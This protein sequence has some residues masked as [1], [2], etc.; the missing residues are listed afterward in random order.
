MG[1]LNVPTQE[2]GVLRLLCVQGQSGLHMA[3]QTSQSYTV[4]SG[5]QKRKGKNLQLGSQLTIRVPTDKIN[6]RQGSWKR[7]WHKG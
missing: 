6:D 4:R 7:L 5:F 2:A 3:F 1:F